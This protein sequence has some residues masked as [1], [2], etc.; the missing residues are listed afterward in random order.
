MTQSTV[1]DTIKNNALV[2]FNAPELLKVKLQLIKWKSFDLLNVLEVFFKGVKC[3][4][5]VV[6]NNI[7]L[8]KAFTKKINNI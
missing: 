7:I 6:L 1:E 8:E 3:K 4:K 5:K 2:A